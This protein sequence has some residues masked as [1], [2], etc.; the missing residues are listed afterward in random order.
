MS[1]SER[2]EPLGLISLVFV[3]YQ[4]RMILGH[5]SAE[6]HRGYLHV[7]DAHVRAA[8]ERLERRLSG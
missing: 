5:E 2:R 7:E 1:E 4:I 3:V 8:L 6:V